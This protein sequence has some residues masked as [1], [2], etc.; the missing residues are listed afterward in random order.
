V[1][2]PRTVRSYFARYKAK[3]G[4]LIGGV[5]HSESSRFQKRSDARCRLESVLEHNEGNAE[6][7]VVPSGLPPEIL[8]HC[9]GS[10]GQARNGLCFGCGKKVTLEDAREVE[11]IED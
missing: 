3:K 1:E 5:T 11:A 2:K 4:T 8:S 10:M 6:G 9:P 7:E